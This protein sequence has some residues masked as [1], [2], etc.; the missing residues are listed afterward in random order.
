MA[1][2]LFGA[3]TPASKVLLNT[4]TSFQLA[5]FLY[6]G[7]AIGVL[8]ILIKSRKLSLPWRLNRANRTRLLST[9]FFGGILGPVLLLFG[10]KL[11]SS[12]SV[13]LWLNL[14][15]V[16][17]II[18]G[19]LFFHD[20]LT[21]SSSA[22]S[23]FT[24][25]A[26]VLLSVSEGLAGVIAGIFVFLACM[27]WGM[28][29][30]LTALIDGIRPA[31]TTF[32]KGVAGGFVNLSIG[33]I[34]APFGA[35][36]TIC[37]FALGVG[38]LSYGLSIVL[39]ITSAQQLGASR[40]QIVFSSSP[41]FA[42]LFSALFLGE[43]ISMLQVFAIVLIVFS[44]IVLMYERHRH[45]HK[46]ERMSHEHLH[47]HDDDHH[48]HEHTQEEHTEKHTHW[49]EHL[50]LIHTHSHWPDLHHRHKH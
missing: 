47:H 15:L 34:A 14:E 32:W 50:P 39:Y 24:L 43:V 44:F 13:A 27:C 31:E 26:A 25:T 16:A 19:F 37:S 12:A 10:L 6:L 11:A 3:S 45:E 28:D 1:A 38:I 18:L 2:V 48:A 33:F 42:V 41:F 29:N 49:H 35:T 22:A 20:R 4:L 40:S 17:T 21:F 5:G 7:S 9:I 46:H 8:P 36:F 30:H 23:V